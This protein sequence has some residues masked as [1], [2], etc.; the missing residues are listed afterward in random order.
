MTVRDRIRDQ[1]LPGEAEAAARSWPVVEA[2]LAAQAPARRSRRPRRVALRLALVALALCVG[3]VAALTP[4]GAE[5][6]D[7]IGDRFA[8]RADPARPAFAG[9]PQGP[10]V[11]AISRSGAYAVHS[12]GLASARLVLRRWLVAARIERGGS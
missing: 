4:A 10:S 9:L 8:D 6:G 7:W 12:E 5:V 1:P 11:L 3:L 2:A